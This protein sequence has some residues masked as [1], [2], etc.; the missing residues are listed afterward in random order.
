MVR[1]FCMLWYRRG[2]YEIYLLISLPVSSPSAPLLVYKQSMSEIRI[3]G[4]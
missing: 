4:A 2:S 3:T 1:S